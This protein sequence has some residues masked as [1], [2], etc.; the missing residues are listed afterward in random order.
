MFAIV[1]SKFESNEVGPSG[2]DPC[3]PGSSA[4][5]AVQFSI[6][7]RERVDYQIENL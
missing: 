4:G 1:I 2:L 6:T 5:S 3:S 7:L